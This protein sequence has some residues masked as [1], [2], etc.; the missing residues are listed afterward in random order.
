MIGPLTREARNLGQVMT[1]ALRSYRIVNL[2]LVELHEPVER[3]LPTS[4]RLQNEAALTGLCAGCQIRLLLGRVWLLQ[5]GSPTTATSR[6]FRER[7]FWR[8]A[9]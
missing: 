4:L 6:V 9:V 7:T 2:A 5:A 1:T 8:Q 3:L